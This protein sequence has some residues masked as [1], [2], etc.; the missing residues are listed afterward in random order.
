MNTTDR[1]VG[2]IDYALRRRFAFY[3]IQANKN[4][5][6]RQEG[7]VGKKAIEYYEKVYEHLKQNPSSDINLDDL[8][9]GHSY[10][11]ADSISSLDLKWKYEVLPL[12]DEYFKD[13]L[14]SKPFQG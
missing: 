2:T 4:I 14:I 6:S 13:G 3:T 5:V 7:E 10:F 8:M 9:I 12:L 1:S 11:L